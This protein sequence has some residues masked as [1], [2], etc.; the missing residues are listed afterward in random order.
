MSINFDC[1]EIFAIINLCFPNIIRIITNFSKES[2]FECQLK[3][4]NIEKGKAQ[5]V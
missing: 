5:K 2:S 3:E 4:V 1:C